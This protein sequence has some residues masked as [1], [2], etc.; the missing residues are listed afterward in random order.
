MYHSFKNPCSS[1]F[2]FSMHWIFCTRWSQ[3]CY[4][5][6]E[7]SVQRCEYADSVGF[8]LEKRR[9]FKVRCAFGI[10]QS[11]SLARNIVSQIHNPIIKWLLKVRI[12]LFAV[13]RMCIYGGT[14]WYLASA[15]SNTALKSYEHLL[16]R[17]WILGDSPWCLSILNLCFQ[18]CIM[19]F[20]IFFYLYIMYCTSI[21]MIHNEYVLIP[22]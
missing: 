12:A 14:N 3:W 7:V 15:F 22:L 8:R 19:C 5:K 11:H 13:L 10:M 17:I 20:H 1:G 16:S 9:K 6:I 21:K 2:L 18:A 4:I